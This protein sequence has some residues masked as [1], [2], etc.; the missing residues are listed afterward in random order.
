MVGDEIEK[1]EVRK[2]ENEDIVKKL[3]KCEKLK[4]EYLAG[5]QRARADFLNYKKDEEK[6]FKEFLDDIH[7]GFILEL[8]PVLDSF[9]QAGKT[10]DKKNNKCWEDFLKIKEQF[11]GI[12][13]KWGV[14]EISCQPGDKFDP[15]F[16][17]TVEVVE[18]EA[19]EPGQIV[20][21]VQKGYKFKGKILRPVRVKVAK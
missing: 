8:L 17:E 16:Q 20:E 4:D 7:E 14:E 18:N 15:N 19:Q 5:W 2:M 13:A 10:I 21:V 3:E 1:M 11:L 12:L 9:D 6:R